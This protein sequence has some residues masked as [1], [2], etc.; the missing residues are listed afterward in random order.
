[1]VSVWFMFACLFFS[2]ACFVYECCF[3]SVIGCGGSVLL[4]GSLV[5]ILRFRPF[6]CLRSC[7]I[8]YDHVFVSLNRYERKKNI[9]LAIDAAAH[10]KTKLEHTSGEQTQQQQQRQQKQYQQKKEDAQ[11]ANEN[12]STVDRM[13][14]TQRVLLVVAGG[15]DLRVA[16][17]VEYLQ[18]T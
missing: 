10:L 17:N 9:F 7:F 15:Y 3:D 4:Y 5:F 11:I 18:V 1:M 14:T 8:G 6:K 12:A 16:E 13:K 2:R